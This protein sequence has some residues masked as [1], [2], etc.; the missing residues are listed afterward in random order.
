MNKTIKI[1]D[2]VSYNQGVQAALNVLKQ[3]FFIGHLDGGNPAI[4]LIENLMV[5]VE[6]GI[7]DD[8]IIPDSVPEE[9]VEQKNILAEL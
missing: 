7:F 3:Q 4:T 5:P 2:A 9:V 1:K 6:N 8:L